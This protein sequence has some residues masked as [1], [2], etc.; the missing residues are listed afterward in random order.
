MHCH[1]LQYL[2]VSSCSAVT[3]ISMHALAQ[4]CP[5]LVHLDI[6]WCDMI[7]GNGIKSLA[8]GCRKLQ[9]FIAKGWFVY[10]FKK[11]LRRDFPDFFP[12][13]FYYFSGCMHIHDEGLMH[14]AKNCTDLR[15]VNVQ[16]CRNIQDEGVIRLAESCPELA[17][18]CVSNCSH[19][20]DAALL[21]MSANCSR[22]TTLECAS[23]SQFTDTGF[24]SL[25][26]N[27]HLLERLDLEECVLIT[28]STLAALSACCPRLEFI[29]LSHCELITDEG[30]RQLGMAPCSSEHLIVLELDNLPLITDVSLDHLVSCHNLQRIELYDCQL[31]TRAGIRRLRNHLPNIRV[32]AYFAPITP[33]PS[34]GG[35]RQRYCRCCVI[36]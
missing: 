17:Y 19:L 33:P 35:T 27:C 18:L 13:T 29:S 14:L 6:S 1:K 11:K 31:I 8:E 30:I 28:D 7:T 3:D 20:T 4:G 32:H 5:N 36:L 22:L 9:N 12:Q 15:K 25:A 2:D 21:S 16:G 24:G 26:R 23:V 34:I 10:R